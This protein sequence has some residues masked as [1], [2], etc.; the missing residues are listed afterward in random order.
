M[1]SLCSI[2]AIRS[3]SIVFIIFAKP[4]F[5]FIFN[6]QTLLILKWLKKYDLAEKIQ[7]TFS[8]LL[9]DMIDTGLNLLL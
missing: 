7:T 2:F 4:L 5:L 3:S 8:G 1:L 9:I 6:F